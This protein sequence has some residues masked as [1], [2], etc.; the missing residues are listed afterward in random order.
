[1]VRRFRPYLIALG[2]AILAIG[3]FVGVVG[4]LF[5]T[6]GLPTAE[7]T[8]LADPQLSAGKSGEIAVA[9]DNTGD[10]IIDPLCITA[11]FSAA[12]HVDQVTFDN[13]YPYSYRK[14]AG[15][16]GGSLVGQETINVVV[17][18][19]PQQPGDLAIT[20]AALQGDQRVG[21]PLQRQ[22]RV[23]G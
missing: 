16:C 19:T 10:S 21:T 9:V 1:M 15:Y 20:I 12:V 22:V 6:G 11:S 4:P 8:G 7:V 5:K 18:V 14:G 23:S 17:K 13:N 2:V 3:A